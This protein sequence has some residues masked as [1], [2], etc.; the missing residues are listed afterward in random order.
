MQKR[1]IAL[2]C[3]DIDETVDAF[4]WVCKKHVMQ[5]KY[6]WL[7]MDMQTIRQ[8]DRPVWI[9]LSPDRDHQREVWEDGYQYFVPSAQ[10]RFEVPPLSKW[11]EVTLDVTLKPSQPETA[12]WDLAEEIFDSFIAHLR[13]QGYKVQEPEGP[14]PS[15]DISSK[16]PE[17]MDRF[18]SETGEIYGDKTIQVK[19]DRLEPRPP[20]AMEIFFAYAHEDEELRDEL[21]KHLTDLKRQGVIATWHD[22]KIGPGKEWEGEI[23]P[24][25]NTAPVI[26]LL[27][28][29]DFIASDYCMNVEVKRA[30]ERHEDGEARVIP[31]ILRQ[32]HW[33]STPFGKLKALPTDGKPV[34]SWPDRDEAFFD[35]AQGIRAAVVDLRLIEMHGTRRRAYYTLAEGIQREVSRRTDYANLDLNARQVKAMRYL[36]KHGEITLAIYCEEIAPRI[37]RRMAHQDL[38]DLAEQG[39]VI[40]VGHTRGARHVLPSS[41]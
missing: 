40:R 34:T 33:K 17:P 13:N 28:S 5:L 30:M 10:I 12:T 24:H 35:V 18:A 29:P 41:E 4:K 27:I 23:D 6:Q 14:M 39:L 32:V 37:S 22:R 36:E 8:E 3:T 21:E 25:L 26:L 31:V 15:E 2:D 20:K 38:R 16:K 7:G 19:E 9:R 11:Q 1:K